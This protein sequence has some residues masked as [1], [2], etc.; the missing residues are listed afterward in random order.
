MALK[1]RLR[2]QGRNN[3]QFYRL[4]VA[5]ARAPRDGHYVEA[6]GWYNPVETKDEDVLHLE[7]QRIQYWIEKGAQVSESAE[8]LLAKGAPAI[9]K[10]KT[11]RIV[12]KRKRELDKHKRRK[13][14]KLESG[15][16]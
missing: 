10:A 3:R 11:E 14:R 6:L 2:Q 7:P 4:V 8:A 15:K 12:A 13:T 5:D 9:L 1:I 16:K